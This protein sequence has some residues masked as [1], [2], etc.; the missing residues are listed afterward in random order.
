MDQVLLGHRPGPGIRSEFTLMGFISGSGEPPSPAWAALSRAWWAV[1][2]SP[3]AGVKS[4]LAYE[5][6]TDGYHF[7]PG[8]F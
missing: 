7:F 6:S 4:Q 8:R 3:E 2:A 1:R 5:P